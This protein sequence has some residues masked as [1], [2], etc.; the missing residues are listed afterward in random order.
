MLHLREGEETST[1]FPGHEGLDSC[2]RFLYIPVPVHHTGVARAQHRKY[3]ES[4]NLQLSSDCE[5]WLQ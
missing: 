5:N 2:A 1:P 4:N 3:L